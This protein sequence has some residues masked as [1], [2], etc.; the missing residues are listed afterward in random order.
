MAVDELHEAHIGLELAAGLVVAVG[1]KGAEDAAQPVGKREQQ[2]A[3]LVK[4]K[5][6]GIAIARSQ[7][8]GVVGQLVF[9]S[10]VHHAASLGVDKL[11]ELHTH[12]RVAEDVADGID[13]IEDDDHGAVGAVSGHLEADAV[14]EEGRLARSHLIL[15]PFASE[16]EAARCTYDNAHIGHVEAVEEGLW[17][18]CDIAA[19]ATDVFIVGHLLFEERD[20]VVVLHSFAVVG[21]EDSKNIQHDKRESNICNKSCYKCCFHRVLCIDA[22][23]AD[24]LII[25]KPLTRILGY[26]AL[27]PRHHEHQSGKDD[28][29]IDGPSRYLLDGGDGGLHLHLALGRDGSHVLCLGLAL[30]LILHSA[31]CL[32]VG[33]GCGCIGAVVV[34]GIAGNV[35]LLAILKEVLVESRTNARGYDHTHGE[36][37]AHPG[38][39]QFVGHALVGV[40]G[41]ERIEQHHTRGTDDDGPLHALE[42]AVGLHLKVHEQRGSPNQYEAEGEE[43][44]EVHALVVEQ[45]DRDEAD[46]I[47]QQNPVA[48]GCH[49]DLFGL[50]GH[51]HKDVDQHR[52]GVAYH[53]RDEEQ[54]AALDAARAKRLE[55]E[56]RR[57]PRLL[58]IDKE[59]GRH[60]ANHRGPADGGVVVTVV[61]LAIYHN[62]YKGTAHEAEHHHIAELGKRQG[63]PLGGIRVVGHAHQSDEQRHEDGA[64][65]GIIDHLPMVIVGKPR[66]KPRTYLSEQHEEKVDDGLARFLLGIER[67]PTCL[68]ARLVAWRHI[69]RGLDTKPILDEGE[70]VAHEQRLSHKSHDKA[71]ESQNEQAVGVGT[72]VALHR[73]NREAHEAHHLLASHAD[74]LVE[75]RRERRHAY[76]RDKADE[77]DVF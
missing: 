36:H 38:G 74:Q 39:Q 40:D 50:H 21:D 75:E 23:V 49:L 62:I 67:I 26:V 77:G 41:D 53:Q 18:G 1:R 20:V 59:Q 42:H 48:E 10:G 33:H 34:M 32:V 72:D 22:R 19:G 5:H 52:T 25:D 24:C 14:G 66:R 58:E 7:K 55:H 11:H 30:A 16:G 76:R 6:I 29:G 47:A 44:L 65:H 3:T 12:H 9:M 27:G 46:E 71:V 64:Q 63:R 73:Q 8:L 13:A 57:A 70:E 31:G 56:V 51:A 43:P 45:Q 68:I 61:D 17:E 35:I 69:A 2:Q 37:D 15:N 54:Y 60:H 4:G 28:T